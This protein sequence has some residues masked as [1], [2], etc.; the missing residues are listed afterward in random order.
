MPSSRCSILDGMLE[1][2]MRNH[3]SFAAW[4]VGLVL[5]VATTGALATTYDLK[6][7]FSNV[8]NPNGAWSFKTGATLLT[9]FPQ[10]SDGNTLN[11][12]AGNGYW[13]VGSS[14][15]TLTP[16]II[17]TTTNGSGAPPFTDAD[18]LAGDVIAHSTNPG[19]GAFHIDWT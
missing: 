4:T 8:S 7:D 16:E 11:P 10:P 2:K 9:H 19:G 5:A 18:F 15:N 1:Q 12:A 3:S 17:K 6:N 14:F 13:G